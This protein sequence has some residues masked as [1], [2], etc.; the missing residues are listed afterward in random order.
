MKDSASFTRFVYREDIS[1]QQR[2]QLTVASGLKV[3]LRIMYVLLSKNS[4]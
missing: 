4:N 3:Y 2:I 1:I